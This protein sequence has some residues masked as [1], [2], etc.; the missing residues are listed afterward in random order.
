MLTLL[1]L[2]SLP[3]LFKGRLEI[4][5][6]AVLAVPPWQLALVAILALLPIA[7]AG[8]DFVPGPAQPTD[9]LILESTMPAISPYHRGRRRASWTCAG[10]WTRKPPYDVEP[11]EVKPA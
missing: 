2:V 4:D 1:S 6:A 5:W 10:G 9:A 11:G 8:G 7:T 3:S